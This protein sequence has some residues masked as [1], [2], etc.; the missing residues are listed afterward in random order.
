MRPAFSFPSLFALG[1]SLAFSSACTGG[2]GSS[3]A[4]SGGPAGS[5]EPKACSP[6]EGVTEP[7]AL[8]TV[9]GAGRH[10]DGTIYVVDQQESDLRAFVSEGSALE[11]KKVAGSGQGEDWTSVT[12]ADA[13]APFSLKVETEAGVP[14]RMGVVR[15]ELKDKTFDVGAQGDVL[16]LV[17]ASAY[18]NLAIRNI[19]G[20]VVVAYDASTSDGRRIVVTRPDVDWSYEDFRVFFGTPERMVE[21]RVETASRGSSTHITFDVD[22]VEHDAVFA[23]TMSSHTTSTL[24][25]NGAEEGLTVNTT[26]PG[27]GLSYFCL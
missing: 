10:A 18:A 12:I 9:I 26:D 25:V 27:V 3:E 11:R 13:N 16:E 19:P 4:A 20:S 24:T 7:I 21:R 2:G 1:F 6:L 22:G 15:G 23:S 8:A 5:S 14:K 17:D